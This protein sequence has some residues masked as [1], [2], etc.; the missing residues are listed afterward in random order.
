MG[1][2]AI[3]DLEYIFGG[4][5]GGGAFGVYL[6]PKWEPFGAFVMGD[7]RGTGRGLDRGLK[8]YYFTLVCR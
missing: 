8:R 3:F 7:E 6:W 1:Y 4:L 2:G 5:G